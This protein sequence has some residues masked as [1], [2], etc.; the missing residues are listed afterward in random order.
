[1]QKNHDFWT[2]QFNYQSFINHVSTSVFPGTLMTWNC[3]R[4]WEKPKSCASFVCR[5]QHGVETQT[6]NSFIGWRSQKRRFWVDVKTLLATY[7]NTYCINVYIY[8]Q[9]IVLNLNIYIYIHIHLW[10]YVYIIYDYIC[11]SNVSMYL[12]TDLK[13]AQRGSDTSL[14]LRS[15]SQFCYGVVILGLHPACTLARV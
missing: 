14:T 13:P 15:F 10:I 3:L 2:F 4:N 6:S 5:Q 11:V 12:L 9:I 8:T 1:M 7:T